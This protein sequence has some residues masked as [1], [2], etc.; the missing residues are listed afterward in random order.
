MALSTYPNGIRFEIK[1]SRLLSLLDSMRASKVVAIYGPVGSGKTT[2]I[3]QYLRSIEKCRYVRLSP[4]ATI[5]TIKSLLK[6]RASANL[7]I[8]GVDNVELESDCYYDFL[9]CARSGALRAKIF[10]IGRSR[11]RLGLYDLIRSGQASMLHS[12]DLAFDADEIALLLQRSGA[13]YRASDLEW[14]LHETDGWPLVVEWVIRHAVENGRYLRAALSSWKECYARLLFEILADTYGASTDGFQAFE[15]LLTTRVVAQR[16]SMRLQQLEQDGYP[17]VRTD[18]VVR[19]YRILRRL[20]ASQGGGDV[21]EA[22]QILAPVM[23]LDVLGS[24]RCSIGGRPV[25]FSRKRDRDVFIFIALQPSAHVSREILL[26]AFWSGID[27][28][29]AAQGLR[30]TI[31][32]IRRAIAAAAPHVGPDAYFSTS[33]DLRIDLRTVVVDARQFFEAVDQAHADEIFGF[34]AQAKHNYRLAYNIYR[35]PLL[36]GEIVERCLVRM[37]DRLHA[38]Y[39]QALGRLIQLHAAAGELDHA[40]E[41]AR[42]FLAH[43]SDGVSTLQRLV[44]ASIG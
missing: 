41:Y 22:S 11:R 37:S 9:E 20:V 18:G 33:G 27:R 36:A 31:S 15:E 1:R 14:L 8:D 28:T 5:V 10:L 44:N 42:E 4:S 26:E 34:T 17:V 40:R 3:K 35:Q 32:R 16:S 21:S 7:I 24:W 6:S 43:S 2:L 23:L 38:K 13:A 30:T 29:V 12:Y 25:V 19:P 39:M